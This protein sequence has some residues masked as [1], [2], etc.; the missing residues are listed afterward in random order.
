MR[1]SY[2][3][4]SPRWSGAQLPVNG[5][6]QSEGRQ[7][8]TVIRPD[9]LVACPKTGCERYEKGYSVM[10]NLADPQDANVLRY[11]REGKAGRF[12]EEVM[13]VE[14]LRKITFPPGHCPGHRPWERPTYVVGERRTDHDEW[15][16]RYQEGGEALVKAVKRKM[17]IMED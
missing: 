2:Y 8:L 1:K 7:R 4:P 3:R 13:N 14:R 11:V 16:Y 9:S 10:L 15:H 17:E 6:R 5:L 12:V